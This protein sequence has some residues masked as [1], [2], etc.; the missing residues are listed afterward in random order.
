LK[1]YYYIVIKRKKDT[2]QWKYIYQT[3]AT[4]L[5]EEL[6]AAQI[7]DATMPKFRLQGLGLEVGALV[8]GP[9]LTRSNES[10]IVA[11]KADPSLKERQTLLC[12]CK[13]KYP[14]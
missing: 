1:I 4:S 9:Q 13:I 5:A 8:N 11:P 3:P 10:E 2:T 14:R 12:V 7:F 6:A